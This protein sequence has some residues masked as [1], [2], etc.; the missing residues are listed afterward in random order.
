MANPTATPSAKLPLPVEVIGADLD[1]Q[2]FF[3]SAR[4]LTIHR[5]GVSILVAN[6][7]APDSEL[8]VRNPKTNKE[9]AAFVIGQIR[10][11]NAGY[12]Y[13]LAFLDPSAD[14]WPM[15]LPD[16][17]PARS[18]LLECS[19]CHTVSSLSLSGI[20]LEIFEAK[21]EFARSCKIC[22]SSRAWKETRKEATKIQPATPPEQ[23][24]NP[25]AAP[26]AIEEKRKTRR[27]R[28]K[29]TACIRYS[30]WEDVVVCE[31][32]SKGGFRFLG[33]REYR[34]GTRVE[35]S[36]PYTESNN[37]M[38]SRA[39]IVYCLKLPDGQFRHGVSFTKTSGS[40]GWDP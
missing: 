14:L 24:L 35:V 12:V 2:Q 3:E 33:R 17:E 15:Q 11:D 30:G 29:M 25:P 38:F 4:I 19:G 9:A 39:S 40:I 21:K 5:N 34:Q 26:S 22:K 37:N 18:V 6:K 36:A 13:G 7:L 27:T 32:I 28:M 31:D 10:E 16:P 8:L 23:K 1:G 20:D